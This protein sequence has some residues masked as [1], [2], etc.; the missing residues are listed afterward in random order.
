LSTAV[1][2]LRIKFQHVKKTAQ[3]KEDVQ[4]IS[5]TLLIKKLTGNNNVLIIGKFR[6]LTLEGHYKMIQRAL[7][8]YDGVIVD[9][10]TSKDT[11]NTTDLR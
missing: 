8:L 5:K 2:N 1:G 7:N 6:V 9:I 11:K 3:I 4:L 10:V